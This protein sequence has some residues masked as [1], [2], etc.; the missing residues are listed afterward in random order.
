SLGGLA[1]LAG[2]A[3]GGGNTQTEESLAVLRSQEF[4]EAFIE[5]LHLMPKL[6]PKRWDERT[7][8]WKTGP[9]VE[10]PTLAQAFKYF[11][12]RIRTIS[13]DKKTGLVT[14]QIRWK[15]RQEATAW[16][17]ALVERL[18]EEMRSRAITKT[19][20]SLGFLEKELNAT[21][22]VSTRE[23]INRLIEAQIKQRML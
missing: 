11:D 4:T 17:N 5:S 13:Q 10:P 12:G 15:N 23:A 18:N 9:G 8:T 14:V 19:E 21:A 7:G 6:F 1:S 20:A 2:F 22:V 16:A 3:V